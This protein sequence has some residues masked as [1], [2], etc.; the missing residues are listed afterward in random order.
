LTLQTPTATLSP[1][2][3]LFRSASL[4]PPAT[5]SCT[6]NLTAAVASSTSVALSSGSAFVGVPP[7]VTVSAGASSA[8]F[9]ANAPSVVSANGSALLMASL[10]SVSLRFT[11]T[12]NAPGGPPVLS[13]LTCTPASLTPPGTAS[14]TVSLSGAA[15]GSTSV[16]LSSGNP[17]VT[18]P[19]SVTIGSGASSIG[20]TANAPAAVSANG[21]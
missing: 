17:S 9:T 18:V 12:L 5:S 19:P 13:N 8:G 1:S 15:T 4:T 10:N 7:S 16:S 6:V 14:C 21:S 3:P 20:F 2:T 11:L